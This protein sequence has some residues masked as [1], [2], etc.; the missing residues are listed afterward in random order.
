MDGKE[1]DDDLM[2]AIGQGDQRSY[3]VMVER[4]LGRTLSVAQRVL[5][6]RAEAEE[7][8]QEALLRLW[9]QA[10][11]W[12]PGGA[13]VSTWLYRVAFN[14]CLDRRRRPT[15]APLEAAGDLAADAPD[16]FDAVRASQMRRALDDALASLPERQRAVVALCLGDDLSQQEAAEVLGVTEGAIESLLVRARRSLREKLRPLMTELAE[17]TP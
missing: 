15:M 11:R 6:S 2:Q 8:A 16:G 10:P 9:T 14:L 4:H 1:S 17:D 13:K 12:K 3:G 7:V 5:G